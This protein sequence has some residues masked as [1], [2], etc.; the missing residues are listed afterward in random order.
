MRMVVMSIGLAWAPWVHAA[1]SAVIHATTPSSQEV[2]AP[3]APKGSVEALALLDRV[4]A[5]MGGRAAIEAIPGVR[6]EMTVRVD[7]QD[8]NPVRVSVIRAN[9][10]AARIRQSGGGRADGEIGFDGERGWMSD[11]Q[12]GFLDLAPEHARGMMQGADLQAMLRDLRGRYE[13]FDLDPPSE[14]RGKQALVLR[15]VE[16]DASEGDS[17][18]VFLDPATALP[19]GLESVIDGEVRDVNRV[20]VEGWRE[21]RG[22]KVFSKMTIDRGPIRSLITFDHVSFESISAGEI[23]SPLADS[24]SD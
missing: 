20:V 11:G 15:C 13:R 4:E 10:F 5:A 6:M 7:E 12:G 2:A 24:A 3:I 17:V 9:P 21:E 14:F 16:L 18:R 22:I 8:P 23:R 19:L 1:E